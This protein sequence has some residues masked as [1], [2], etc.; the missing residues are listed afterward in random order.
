MKTI[1]LHLLFFSFIFSIQAQNSALKFDGQEESLTVTHNDAYNIGDG[2]TIEAWIFAENWRDASWQGSIVAKDNQAPDRGFAFRCGDNGVLSFVMSV[3]NVWEEAFSA[4]IMNANQWHHVATVVNDGTITLFIDGQEVAS[5][6][7]TGTPV[8]G[9]DL[10]LT[11]G[12]SSGFGG[13]IFDGALDEVRIWDVARTQQEIADN[14]TVDLSGAEPGLIAYYPMNEG[15]GLVAGDKSGTANN[16]GL[17]QMDDSNWVEGYSLPDFD[18]SVQ[19][20]YGIDVVNMIDR[21]IKLKVDIQNTGTMPISNIDLAVEV[22]GNLYN[23]ETVSATIAAN[24]LYTYTFILPVDIIGLTDP[25][26]SVTA[27]QAEDGNSLNNEG[28]IS[29]KTGTKTNVIVSDKVL[30]R[31]GESLQSTQMTLP[32]DLH[33]YEQMILTID[34][35]CPAGGCAPWDVLADLKAVT[36]NGTYE[37]AR[38]VTPFGKACG[39]WIVDITDF[40]SVLGGEVEFLT[41]IAVFTREGWLV[42]MS[43]ELID[44]NPGS[45]F[46]TLSKLWERSYQVYG[47]P[48][49]SYDLPEVPV[50]VNSN[51]ETSHVRMTISGH[52][53]GNTNNAAEFFDVTHNLNIGGQSFQDHRLWKSDCGNNPCDDQA[54]S[55]PFNRAGWCPGQ[56]V[57]P[58][59]INTTSAMMPGSEMRFD[60]VL[61]NYTN[62]LNTGYNNNGHTEPYYRIFSYFVEESATAYTEYNNLAINTATP[63]QS[64]NMLESVMVEIENTGLEA[65]TEYTV[66]IFYDGK[67]VA[68]QDFTESIDVDATAT[69]MITVNTAIVG[70]ADAIFAEVV[71]SRDDN[72]GDNVIKGNLTTSTNQIFAQHQFAV[73]PNPTPD[74]QVLLNYDQFW[75]GSTLQIYSVSGV[76]VKEVDLSSAVNAFQLNEEGAYLYNVVHP[77]HGQTLSGKLFFVR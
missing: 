12:G 56:A 72:L 44:N 69:Q 49:I 34:L 20:V 16:A 2:F 71:N 19:D 22:D 45:T 24:E 14:S 63:T 73:F 54:G 55:W 68:T 32:N 47:D 5:S 42:D 38:Y 6:S 36:S 11:I 10:N 37:L 52:G 1:L 66:N 17:N 28:S 40:K 23:T 53:Q 8:N 27:S 13:R 50:M 30:H 21:P 57:D 48:N 39:G 18:I 59:V 70:S 26:I 31:N 60:Y 76:L 58:F 43:V 29:I 64:N 4:Q 35:S 75:N 41:N 77:E 15:S 3:D 62:L 65:M 7:Y 74:G 46:S 9:T 67:M 51:S 33:K 25:E 61:Q